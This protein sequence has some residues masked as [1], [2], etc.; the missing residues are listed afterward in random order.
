MLAL[1]ILLAA[2]CGA[3]AQDQPR[4][5]PPCHVS[6]QGLISE[7]LTPLTFSSPRGTYTMQIVPIRGDFH[8]LEADLIITSAVGSRYRL[9]HVAGHAFFVTDNGRVVTIEA[10]EPTA[11]PSRVQ[12]LDLM[13]RELAALDVD[14][15]SDPVLATDGSCLAYRSRDGIVALSLS[16]FHETVYPHLDL[17][18][19]GPN[20]RVAGV[21]NG[22]ELLVFDPQDPPL[23]LSLDRRPRRVCFSWDG[24]HLLLLDPDALVRVRIPTGERD[25]LITA[26][27]GATLRD[28]RITASATYVGLRRVEGDIY[29]GELI[30]L[31]PEGHVLN[32]EQGPSR[33]IPRAADLPLTT[34]GIPWPLEPNAQHPVGN[35]YGEFQ[36]YGASYLHPGVDVMGSP[37]QP[38]Y[39]VADGVV[40]AILTTSGEWHWR[41]A[42]GEPTGGTSVGYLYAHVEETSIAVDVGDPVVA[43]QYL[44]V[45]VEWPIYDFTHVHFARIEDSGWQWFGNWLCTDNP[46]L[47]LE[48]QTETEIPIFEPARGSDLLAFCANQSSDYQEPDRLHGEVDIIAHVGDTIGSDWVCSVQEIRYTIYPAGHPDQPIVDD[49]LAVSFDMA[50]D[51]Y[52]SG[53]IDPFLV[54]LLYKQDSVCHT[55]G[56]YEQREFFHIVSNSDGDQ[57]YDEQDLWEAWDT[58]TLPDREYVIRVTAADVVGNTAIDSMIVT[59][60]NGNPVSVSLGTP[61]PALTLRGHPNPFPNQTQV[62]FLLPASAPLG[63]SIYDLSGRL[64]RNL[65]Q[66]NLAGGLHSMRWDGRNSRGEEVPS[67]LYFCRLVSPIGTRT[68]RLILIR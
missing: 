30:S 2:A 53:P 54:D 42:T 55:Y 7:N 48:N 58:S 26:P 19:A 20:G 49:K 31:H 44:G 27:G 39:A 3:S 1:V 45:L 15:L 23:S 12:V 17:F 41:I 56:D 9:L 59:T 65:F 25:L 21:R 14:F 46:H 57:I 38:L 66:S 4:G 28:V 63:L 34:R 35:T 11:L 22:T 52:Q 40:K 62:T 29:F 24:S 67:G 16:D 18:T 68:E 60:D 6:C 10:T 33:Q 61:T 51:T 37:F 50:L 47:D 43:G 32:H 64:V 8:H 36:D 13:G 5:L